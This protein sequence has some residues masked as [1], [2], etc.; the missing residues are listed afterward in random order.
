VADR[1]GKLPVAGQFLQHD[2][3]VERLVVSF[4]EPDDL[5]DPHL[6]VADRGGCGHGDLPPAPAKAIFLPSSVEGERLPTPR[7][8]PGAGRSRSV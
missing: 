8:L 3:L 5:G 2:V 6:D 4:A 1:D 7:T